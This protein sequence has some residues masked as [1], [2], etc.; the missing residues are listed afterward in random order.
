MSFDFYSSYDKLFN[1]L[2]FNLSDNDDEIL[3]QDEV[4]AA[5]AAKFDLFELTPNMSYDTF[6]DKFIDCQLDAEEKSEQAKFEQKVQDT[7][8]RYLQMQYKTNENPRPD[9]SLDTYAQRLAATDA[10]KKGNYSEK[11]KK[12]FETARDNPN[13]VNAVYVAN[14]HFGKTEEPDSPVS[15][16]ISVLMYRLQ[17]ELEDFLNSCS[18]DD[19]NIISHALSGDIYSTPAKRA[20]DDVRDAFKVLE[21][22]PETDGS[23]YIKLWLQD[24]MEAIQAKEF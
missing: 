24:V 5:K 20:S 1:R 8:I 9:E 13:D 19:Y 15:N 21:K 6:V 2:N 11:D 3:D 17:G 16:Y 23:K 22:Y 7:H 12:I 18:S 10:I 14:K 4:N